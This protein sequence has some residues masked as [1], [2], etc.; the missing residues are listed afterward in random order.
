MSTIGKLY[1]Y[2]ILRKEFWRFPY[3]APMKHDL[4]GGSIVQL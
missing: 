4:C 1:G 3:A 2:R